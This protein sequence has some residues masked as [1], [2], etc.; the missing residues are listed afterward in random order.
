[1]TG[2]SQATRTRDAFS[3]L[4]S[5]LTLSIA[6]GVTAASTTIV[7][8][9][10]VLPL[11]GVDI[12]RVSYMQGL[13]HPPGCDDDVKWWA[14]KL[15]SLD[16]LA[17]YT[18]TAAL[19]TQGGRVTTLH[20]SVV[21]PQFFRVFGV[22]PLIGRSFSDSDDAYRA[23]VIVI[24]HRLWTNGRGSL[25][26]NG[27]RPSIIGVLPS[28]FSFPLGT[29]VWLL[30]SYATTLHLS[31]NPLTPGPFIGY[32]GSGWVGL[33]HNAAGVSALRHQANAVLLYLNRT[34]SPVTHVRY[35]EFVSAKPLA[36]VLTM[37]LRSL[38][39]LIVC[40]D[41]LIFLIAVVQSG[42]FIGSNALR[43]SPVLVMHGARRR[44][45]GGRLLGH[46]L[47]LSVAGAVVGLAGAVASFSWLQSTLAPV[48][49]AIS[50]AEPLHR[51]T[52]VVVFATAVLAAAITRTVAA[53]LGRNAGMMSGLSLYN[54]DAMTRYGTLC[55]RCFIIAMTALATMLLTSGAIVSRSRY[56]AINATM[57]FD[58]AHLFALSGALLGDQTSLEHAYDV[59]L[60]SLAAISGVATVAGADNG[61][62]PSHIAK[63]Y[64]WNG[65][66]GDAG[67]TFTVTDNYFT[68]LRIPIRL[69]RSF[70]PFDHDGL[71][72]NARLAT[73]LWS[74]AHA[75]IGQFLTL[76]GEEQ[77]RR[78]IG[79][80]GDITTGP[81]QAISTYQLYLSYRSPYSAS[82]HS[83]VS[84]FLR[85][86]LSPSACLNAIYSTAVQ[87][88]ST[89]QSDALL[90]V[91][92]ALVAATL[93]TRI[94]G[95]A[96][97]LGGFLAL[98]LVCSSI[99][100]ATSLG[101]SCLYFQH[102]TVTALP[103]RADGHRPTMF[104]VLI[105]SA[106]GIILGTIA[107]VGLSRLLASTVTA[108]A[109]PQPGSILIVS[110]GILLCCLCSAR[111]SVQHPLY[112]NGIRIQETDSGALGH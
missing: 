63:V 4:M 19:M 83:L 36:M 79:V 67:V 74:S 50:D 69:G 89:L 58:S 23:A 41:G 14:R 1:M 15:S 103:L 33:L 66:V 91:P 78:I 70:T 9:A 84:F 75:A 77:P 95:H 104:A 3:G 48:L 46:S 61:P 76:D 22:R 27:V 108:A 6:F 102:D 26:I 53:P 32:R 93:P 21:S 45:G 7:R 96:L 31:T 98:L 86:N 82:S 35:G 57:G 38:V 71:I 106:T 87:L 72:V 30:Q 10:L 92:D 88:R 110:S 8:E 29:D 11:G 107:A 5:F 2:R 51:T 80:A 42:A 101:S 18:E 90:S 85:C 16:Y 81:I 12:H 24:S 47:V 65:S 60:R 62:T 49:P 25:L 13:S 40:F 55:Y 43:W 52:V 112:R 73:A 34:V 44:R 59:G 99:Q 56:S 17:R 100:V 105:C 20:I 54:A 39:V 94:A 68:A 97:L 111:L 37:P 28:G 64:F 109:R